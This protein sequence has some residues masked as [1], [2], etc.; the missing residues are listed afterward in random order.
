MKYRFILDNSKVFHVKTMCRVL[1]VSRSRYY[2]WLKEPLSQRQ[3][4]EEIIKERIIY[5]YNESRR[6]YGSPRIHRQMAKDGIHC[7]K[8]RIERIMRKAGLKAVG[9]RRFKVTTD[10]GSNMS[11]ANNVL[12]RN[13]FAYCPDEKWAADI[14]YIHT[15]EGYLYL[16]AVMDLYSKKIVG[17]SMKQRLTQELVVEAMNMAIHARR[18]MPG[19]IVHTDR[20]SQYGS[21]AYRQ[22]L[23]KEG[24]ICSMSRKGNC[25]DNSPMES[26][27]KTLKAELVYHRGFKTRAQARIEIFEY[28]EVFYNRTR[29]HSTLDYKSPEEFERTYKNLIKVT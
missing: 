21:F 15:Y 25:W 26:F 19:L 9:R 24:Y 13:F 3:I 28:I 29:L 23:E 1:K 27:F 6:T 20:G 5:I 10:S 17:Y 7:S 14:T 8:K 16:A 2:S 22:L 18:P 11:V 4:Q 12:D